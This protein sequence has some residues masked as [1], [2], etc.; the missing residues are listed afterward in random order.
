MRTLKIKEIIELTKLANKAGIKRIFF[1]FKRPDVSNLNVATEFTRW[2]GERFYNLNNQYDSI[3]K[4][5]LI[6]NIGDTTAYII[7]EDVGLYKKG[8][9]VDKVIKQIKED[10]EAV[11]KHRASL[12]KYIA[13]LVETS[14]YKHLG[15]IEVRNLFRKKH[16]YMVPYI[17]ESAGDKYN[18][19]VMTYKVSKGDNVI[20]SIAL[21]KV[22]F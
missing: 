20:E 9:T 12:D 13:K 8:Y 2:F 18:L 14:S 4:D 6:L 19:D 10:C 21:L 17:L 3:F 7:R 22:R 11:D 15:Y 1:K 16:I 5:G